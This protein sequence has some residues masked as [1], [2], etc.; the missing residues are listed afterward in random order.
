MWLAHLLT[1]LRLP[2]AAAFWLVVRR[3]GLALLVLALGAATDLIDGPIARFVR[4]WRAARGRPAPAAIGDWLDP[5][6][7]KTFVLSVLLALAVTL[8]P[9]PLV[10]LAIALREVILVPIALVYRFTPLLRARLTYQFRA[11]PVGKAATVAQFLAITAL[12]FGHPW[13]DGLA[14]LA[15]AVG[16]AAAVVY[17]RRGVLLARRSPLPGRELPPRRLPQS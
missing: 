16:L 13:L 7:D 2:L 8:R 3:P 1:I 9:S 11:G 14:A 4:R 17:I 5:L 15:G 12:L 6:C 10:L